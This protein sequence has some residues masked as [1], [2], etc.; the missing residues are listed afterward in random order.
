MSEKTSL[1]DGC[2]EEAF[3]FCSF[4]LFLSRPNWRTCSQSVSQSV[5]QW[6]T[7]R[8]A[9]VLMFTYHVHVLFFC[10]ALFLFFSPLPKF[11]F[12][13]ISFFFKVFLVSLGRLWSSDLLLYPLLAF[14]NC[15]TSVKNRPLFVC[16]LDVQSFVQSFCLALSLSVLTQL[17]LFSVSPFFSL[18]HGKTVFGF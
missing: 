18:R 2:P 13:F 6:G 14:K 5:S 16:S 10:F 4:L 3:L 8:R 7:D 17:C 11:S 15:M 9:W 1:A 12:S